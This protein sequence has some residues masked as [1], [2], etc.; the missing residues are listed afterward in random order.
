MPSQ[1]I[2]IPAQRSAVLGIA[3]VPAGTRSIDKDMAT[4]IDIF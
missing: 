3:V 4:L 2:N 1:D